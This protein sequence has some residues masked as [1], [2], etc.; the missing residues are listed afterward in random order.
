MILFH[1]NYLKLNQFLTPC[2]KKTDKKKKVIFYK[3]FRLKRFGLK[4][5]NSKTV[6]NSLK[7]YQGFLVQH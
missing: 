6:Q 3:K 7:S 4:P 1:I 2:E 5:V